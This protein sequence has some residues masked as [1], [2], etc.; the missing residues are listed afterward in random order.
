[1]KR[2]QL[3]VVVLSLIVSFFIGPLRVQAEGA[4]S[5]T[6]QKYRLEEGIT[7]SEDVPKDGT[8]AEK[9]TDSNGNLLEPLSGIS[10]EIV[11]V[12][13]VEGAST[14]KP[15]EGVDAFTATITTDEQGT[16]HI[17]NLVAGTYR[18]TEKATDTLQHVMEPVTF[19]LP[20]P[21]RTGEALTDIYIY[22]KSSVQNPDTPVKPIEPTKKA[23]RLPQTS[24]NIGTMTPLYLI[25]LLV[26][27]MG[28]IGGHYMRK[29]TFFK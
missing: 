14:F 27:G 3:L 4:Y 8:K 24:G 25:L 18:V 7:L 29:K 23:S 13:P 1:M 10:Y 6:I 2:N 21:Q 22:P 26:I 20:L 15:I 12:T 19:E 5:I 17:G 28:I 16:A 9:V 11:R